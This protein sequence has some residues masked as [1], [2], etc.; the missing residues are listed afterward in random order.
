MAPSASQFIIPGSAQVD[1]QELRAQMMGG[2]RPP[3]ETGSAEFARRA[4]AEADKATLAA[5]EQQFAQPESAQQ[6]GVAP[7]PEAAIPPYGAMPDSTNAAYARDENQVMY[8]REDDPAQIRA[9]LNRIFEVGQANPADYVREPVAG[10]YIA[11]VEPAKAPENINLHDSEVSGSWL[12]QAL[13]DETA[14]TQAARQVERAYNFE[15]AAQKVAN[16]SRFSKA[17]MQWRQSGIAAKD[18]A[19]LSYK[20]G[21]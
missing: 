19:I 4:Q 9:R 5:M 1:P 6:D 20:A 10:E 7:Q 11:P 16:V 3:Q 15:T 8:A 2:Q 14:A 17:L 21:A 13:R 18:A 12:D